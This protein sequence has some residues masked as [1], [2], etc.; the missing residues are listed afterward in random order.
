ME[1]LI[2]EIVKV[3][4]LDAPYQNEETV[5]FLAMIQRI[6]DLMP[7]K[8]GAQGVCKDLVRIIIEETDYENCSILLWD[9]EKKRINLFAAYGLEDLIGGNHNGSYN[10]KLG[11]A[12]AEGIAGQVFSTKNPVFVENVTEE[13][14]PARQDAVISFSSLA[15]LPLLDLGVLNVS[16]R[17]PR[18]FP[19]LIRRNWELL[20]RIVA[21]VLLGSFSGEPSISP[22]PES[23]GASIDSDKAE[24]ENGNALSDTTMMLS[25]HAVN[26]TP[27]GMCLLDPDGNTLHINK[28][29]ETRHGEHVW[30]IIGRS[31]AVLFHDARIF[32]EMLQ[33]VASSGKEE[34]TDVSLVKANGE[35][36]LADVYLVRLLEAD[37]K[38]SGYLLMINDITKK[39]AFA[40]RI[41]QTEKLAALG[42]MAGGVAHDFNNLLMAILGNIQLVLPQIKDEEVLRRLQN[43]EKAV[44]DGAN[45]VRRLQKFNERK[46]GP[47]LLPV[48]VDV[49]EAVNDVVELTR[50]RWKNA[51]ERHGR[52]IKFSIEVEPGCFPAIHASD[53]REVLTNLTLNALEAMPEGGTITFRGRSAKNVIIL[54][55]ADTGI[56]MSEEVASR[57][58]DPFYTTKGVGN[59]GLGLSVS[60]SLIVRCGGEVHV[61]SKPGKGTAFVI[62]MPKAEVQMKGSEQTDATAKK[63]SS[64]LLIVDDDVEILGILRDMLRLKGHRVTATSDSVK[65]L[66][67]IDAGDFDLV[68]TDLGM[69]EV[70]GW[71]IA[72]RAKEKNPKI[73]VVLVTGW[74][75]Q[76]E[77][78]DHVGKG[79]DLVLSKPLSWEKLLMGIERLL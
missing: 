12:P 4:L 49:R 47:Q 24:K 67:L 68:L 48:F 25:A 63:Q 29:I 79:V 44:H 46:R 55:V 53:L 10:G 60:W 2:K 13:S 58:F 34:V 43:I 59:S 61:K 17:T 38:I 15:C 52:S 37:S 18:T 70:N 45:T 32:H 42:T 22:H 3:G 20:S 14:V 27:L 16:S 19:H 9:S 7:C 30:E 74:G 65:A 54:E 72:K 56:G 33:H 78:E 36:Y 1:T 57:I 51:M 69:P 41:L 40:E 73:P 11:F 64:R 31:P 66:E 23:P 75:A 76:Y 39:K 35:L 62:R 28:S 6:I 8:A 77:E 71:D 5:Q 21:Y 50:P 26:H